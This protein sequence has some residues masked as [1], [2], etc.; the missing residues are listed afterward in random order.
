MNGDVPT[1]G[2]F[3][4][5][6]RHDIAVFRPSNGTWYR[7]NSSNN[8]VVAVQF[9]SAEDLP[10]PAD[11]DGDGRTDIAVFRPSNGSWYLLQSQSGFSAVQFGA[12]GD[13]PAPSA[14]QP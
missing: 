9:G 12:S 11:F 13:R 2:D 8:Q 5:D 14:Q 4:A 7:L 1:T 6:G 3:D 10:A